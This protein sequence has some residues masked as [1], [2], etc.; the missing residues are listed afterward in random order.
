M[1]DPLPDY[2]QRLTPYIIQKDLNEPVSIAQG[3]FRLV[4][5]VEGELQADLMFRWIPDGRIE[6]RT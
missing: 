1:P 3:P 5:P 2:P 4:G 6:V